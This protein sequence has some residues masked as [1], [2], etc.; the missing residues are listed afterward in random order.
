MSWMKNAGRR[1]LGAGIVFLIGLAAGALVPQVAESQGGCGLQICGTDTYGNPACEFSFNPWYCDMSGGS[2]STEVCG[3][4]GGQCG[5][6][7][8]QQ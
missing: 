2:C 3:S 1:L 8:C 4:G 6:M 7:E 5:G